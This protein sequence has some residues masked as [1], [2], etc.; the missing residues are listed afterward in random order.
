MRMR[1]I[2][3]LMLISIS[4]VSCTQTKWQKSLGNIFGSDPTEA[5]AAGGLKEALILGAVNSTGL[6]SKQDG[7]FGNQLVK[8]PWPEEAKFVADAL[9]KIGMQGTVDKVTLSLNRAAEKASAEV[10]DVFVGA[11]R[12][13]T[14]QD[15]MKILLGG[16]GAATDYLRRTTTPIL[17]EKFRPIIDKSL[18]E[19]NATRYW[20]DATGAYN[21][22]PFTRPVETDLTAYVT[23]RA[24]RGVFLMMEKEENKLRADPKARTSELLRK[25]FGYADR[26]K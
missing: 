15:A 2:A 12:Q 26:N 17:T 13:M 20:S 19:V 11:I 8:I 14:F 21:K 10:K 18:G 24:L 22:I 6:L 16:D 9:N 1:T 7:F 23:E 5:E 4:L 25:V 3:F